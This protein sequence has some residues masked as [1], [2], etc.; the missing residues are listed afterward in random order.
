MPKRSFEWN[1][2]RFQNL[3]RMSRECRSSMVDPPYQVNPIGPSPRAVPGRPERLYGLTP[4]PGRLYTNHAV[5]D[6]SVSQEDQL[7]R[8]GR[9][10]GRAV[11]A[12]VV[13]SL[14]V[15]WTY[16]IVV[17][18][19]F[20]NGSTGQTAGQSMDSELGGCRPGVRRLIQSVRE[21]R[22]AA[23]AESGGERA[24]LRRF[25]DALGPAWA[26]RAQI[27]RDCNGDAA[28][29]R[30]LRQVDLLRYAEEHAVRYEVQELA[31]RRR[32]IRAIEV[33]LTPGNGFGLPADTVK[34]ANPAH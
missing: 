28:A 4:P 2:H 11:P 20:R 29:T 31:E 18:V 26:K 32:R 12:L 24:A 5:N 19:F 1:R 17:Q 23:A 16:Q 21:A 9:F 27:G 30:A 3:V 34:S 22:R 7:R 8:R 14:T 25:R 13:I 33:E 6:A 10:V 15:L